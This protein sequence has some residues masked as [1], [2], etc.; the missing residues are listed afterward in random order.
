MEQPTEVIS[1]Q[2]AN[3]E[4]FVAES[5]EAARELC[6]FLGKMSTQDVELLLELESMGKELEQSSEQV[7]EQTKPIITR[8]TPAITKEPKPSEVLVESA[9]IEPDSLLLARQFADDAPKELAATPPSLLKEIE[10]LENT[11]SSPLNIINLPEPSADTAAVIFNN[12][13][14]ITPFSATFHEADLSLQKI[15]T[16]TVPTETTASEAKPAL[17]AEVPNPLEVDEPTIEIVEEYAPEL[18]LDMTLPDKMIVQPTPTEEAGDH[19]ISIQ[20]EQV[21]MP[22]EQVTVAERLAAIGITDDLP[23]PVA[24]IK[25]FL[26]ELATVFESIPP[27]AQPQ[28][29]QILAEVIAAPSQEVSL[30]L[31][32]QLCELFDLQPSEEV[33]KSL[34]LLWQ[35]QPELLPLLSP[36]ASLEP[37]QE[38]GTREFLQKLH[39]V[40]FG[41]DRTF[42]R[43]GNLGR[44]ALHLSGLQAVS[45]GSFSNETFAY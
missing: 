27:E 42:R 14:E 1:H 22:A 40:K 30:S 29:Q 15:Q 37:L 26:I 32:T 5:I 38:V 35:A 34:A 33:V 6:P 9:K 44:S 31:I 28:A 20:A 45:A 10:A 7:T 3:G 43:F 25:S 4:A 2:H 8:T 11:P 18:I 24:E 12:P 23:A 41:A 17:I 39:R 21:E 19:P 13:S 36:Q 16:T